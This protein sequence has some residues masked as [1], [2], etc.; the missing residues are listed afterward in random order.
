MQ[1]EKNSKKLQDNRGVKLGIIM[2]TGYLG[3]ISEGHG[4]SPCRKREINSRLFS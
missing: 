1:G 2:P 4:L 3:A